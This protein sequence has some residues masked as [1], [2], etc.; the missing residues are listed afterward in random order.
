[1]QGTVSSFHMHA[2]PR[3]SNS[4][5]LA[6]ARDHPLEHASRHPKQ[7]LKGQRRAMRKKP[8]SITS[9]QSRS[10]LREIEMMSGEGLNRRLDELI[11]NSQLLPLH[12]LLP[13]D[14][15][16][17]I[18][19]LGRNQAYEAMLKFCKRYCRDVASIGKHAS[20]KDIV[21]CY[22]AAIAQ[23]A[24]PPA[25]HLELSKQPAGQEANTYRSGEFLLG[26]LNE[27]VHEYSQDGLPVD[28]NSYTL[29]A[30]LL[31]VDDI[32]ESLE[33][34][35][36]FEEEY[37]GAVTTQVFNV[38][39]ATCSRNQNGWQRA[40]TLLRRMKKLGHT[41]NED[42]YALA[43]QA[44]AHQG[45]V[46]VACSLLDEIRQAN[47]FDVTERLYIPLLKALALKG[48]IGVVESIL[49]LMR[50]DCVA[51]T[52]QHM[53]LYLS[54]ISNGRN[55][56]LAL[57]VL[58]ELVEKQSDNPALSP[59]IYT[60]NTV[61]AALSK[62]GK[63]E[64]AVSLLQRMTDRVFECQVRDKRG[65]F[66][67]KAMRPD[68]VS[69][70]SVIQCSPPRAALALVQE[71]ILTRGVN[72][73]AVTFVNAITQC[74]NAYKLGDPYAYDCFLAVMDI[75]REESADTN[76]YVVGSMIWMAESANDYKLAI[77]LLRQ[78]G[79][80][81]FIA[82]QHNRELIRSVLPQMSVPNTVCYNGVIKSLSKQGM[83]REALYFY[84]EM[85]K[86]SV[87]ANRQTYQLLVYSIENTKNTDV[88]SSSKKKLNL[89]EGVASQMAE[90]EKDCLTS[91]PLWTAIL[92][93]SAA[94]A[95]TPEQQYHSARDRFDSLIG[96]IDEETT[97]EMLRICSQTGK[98]AEAV[99]LLHCSDVYS[100]G[101][102]SMD[103]L[104]IAI[105]TCSK[106]GQWTE[107][108]NL[109]HLYGKND[110]A[111]SVYAVNSI[112]KAAG[113]H[114]PDVSVKLLNEMDSLYGV[115]PNRQSYA[116][117]IVA[118]NQAEHREMKYFSSEI[119][120]ETETSLRWFECA[121]SLYRRMAEEGI[122]ASVQTISSVVSAC[123]AAGEWQRAIGVL[124]ELPAFSKLLGNSAEELDEVELSSGG[125]EAPNLYCINAALSA[126]EKGGAWL[127]AITIYEAV[128]ASPNAPKPNIVTVNSLLIALDRAGQT[129]L[130]SAIY[131]EALLEAYIRRPLKRRRDIDD[132]HRLMVD[133]HNHSGPMA[134]CAVRHYF[135]SI[136]KRKPMEDAVI[137]VGKGNRSKEEPV[138]RSTIVNLLKDEY[139][140]E[141]AVEPS[142]TGRLRIARE[143][144]Q[145][146]YD[147]ANSIHRR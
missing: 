116:H 34:L 143:A 61:L 49:N 106:A 132:K 107:A 83:H 23:L 33:L 139:N 124:Q 90:S 104:N 69:Y 136:I 82:Q 140:V 18:R 70:N 15:S 43:M 110:G 84:Y 65:G 9:K 120:E 12:Y 67:Y 25:S 5:C 75:V 36:F 135:E 7:R 10:L 42:S 109:L 4:C 123:E 51:V 57:Q 50:E 72:P 8:Y 118:C 2:N 26:M 13:R 31:G 80:H 39:L 112:V 71:M 114:A 95:P 131:Q 119:I 129:E 68:T 113:P 141:V 22:T 93:Y 138:L 101:L 133:L 111:V 125:G 27:M 56:T 41:P 102:V 81:S 103:C 45:Q 44:C 122:E 35:R 29:S 53:N 48:D 127:E 30:V 97:V 40:L 24:R 76:S 52:T 86:Q 1:M 77:S 108:M 62:D 130:A 21:H 87:P 32:A 58:E 54:T 134:K 100:K 16:S 126:C 38:A 60:F 98:W 55:S 11:E 46:R 78:V 74:R 96:T 146:Y 85:Q 94:I 37:D 73:N 89:L 145:S 28:P 105:I 92:K 3:R 142:N 6:K 79:T 117:C 66:R 64:D 19:F 99:E 63:Y 115:K 20:G 59:D 17:V 147:I 91:G 128:R 14:A 144:L 88:L 121:L 47:N 137:I